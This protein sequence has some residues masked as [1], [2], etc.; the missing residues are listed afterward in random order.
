MINLWKVSVVHY[1]YL[2]VAQKP[3]LPVPSR[4]PAISRDSDD[5]G[6]GGGPALA[7]REGRGKGTFTCCSIRRASSSFSLGGGAIKTTTNLIL[8]FMPG[9]EEGG[10]V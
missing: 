6:G 4:P 2:A 9:V 5:G 3:L 8:S 10:D 1:L 7:Q